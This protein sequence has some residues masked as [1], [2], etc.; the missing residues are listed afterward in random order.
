MSNTKTYSLIS[1]EPLSEFD[2]SVLSMLN[3]LAG[4]GFTPRAG[5]M[6]LLGEDG[7]TATYHYNNTLQDMMVERGFMDMEISRDYILENLPFFV[8][9]AAENGL[10]GDW[11]DEEEG[12]DDG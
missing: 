8:D 3:D 10:I 11:D 12:D 5:V 7:D 4:S 2:R 6:V 1:N 9:Q